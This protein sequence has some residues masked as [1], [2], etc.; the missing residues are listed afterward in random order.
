M[1]SLLIVGEQAHIFTN[2]QQKNV[3]RIMSNIVVPHGNE[4]ESVITRMMCKVSKS[5][6]LFEG[7]T[8]SITLSNNEQERGSFER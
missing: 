6:C 5:H 7:R 3:V 1:S 2:E 4:Q 8:R